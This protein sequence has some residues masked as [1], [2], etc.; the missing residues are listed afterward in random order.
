MQSSS[1]DISGGIRKPGR[2]RNLEGS[3]Q[4]PGGV[5]GG[6]VADLRVLKR[7]FDNLN[8]AC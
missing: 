6:L 7:L 8:P 3:L 1:N 4:R 5:M 2:R